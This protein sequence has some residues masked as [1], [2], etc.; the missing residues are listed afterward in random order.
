MIP[1]SQADDLRKMQDQPSTSDRGCPTGWLPADAVIDAQTSKPPWKLSAVQKRA[2]QYAAIPIEWR[3][4]QAVPPPKDT[5][6][7]L[8]FSGLLTAEDL[9]CTEIEDVRVLLEQI[10]TRKLS[11]VQVLKAFAKRA[12]I[13]QQLVGCCT[14]IMFAE[15]LERARALDDHLERTGSVVGPLHGLPVSLK[16]IFDVKGVDSTIGKL[17][18][19][20]FQCGPNNVKAGSDSLGSQRNQTVS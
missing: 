5:D 8:R 16:D 9:A 19:A 17:S 11:A 15:A 1:Q 6:A 14:E 2:E 4:D 12:A 3:I 20:G 13:A 10:A 7:F 18:D